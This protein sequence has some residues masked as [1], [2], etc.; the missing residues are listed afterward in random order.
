MGLIQ[1]AAKIIGLKPKKKHK[2]TEEQ[3]ERAAESHARK[4]RIKRA[5][6]EMEERKIALKM[7]SMDLEEAELDTRIAEWEADAADLTPERA[8]DALDAITD[9]DD[10]E[11]EVF[12]SVLRG[13]AQN[14]GKPKPENR[15]SFEPAET[16]IIVT[17][18]DIKRAEEEVN[19]SK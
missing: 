7:R 16:D 3:R 9:A 5:K 14:V 6:W 13:I 11:K 8:L 2:I 15:G 1:I 10:P 18:A 17:N 12:K 4:Q 19:S